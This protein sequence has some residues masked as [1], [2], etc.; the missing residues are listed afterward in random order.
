MDTGNRQKEILKKAPRPGT[1]EPR[2][3]RRASGVA[4]DLVQEGG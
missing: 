2:Q 1:T 3:H 4:F